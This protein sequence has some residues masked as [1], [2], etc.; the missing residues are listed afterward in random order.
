VRQVGDFMDALRETHTLTVSIFDGR[1][2]L[3]TI[4]EPDETNTKAAAGEPAADD[5]DFQKAPAKQAPK[6]TAAAASDDDV[7]PEPPAKR[8]KVRKQ[9]STVDK[10]AAE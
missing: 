8:S 1:D 7:A 9:Q 6:A 10:E 4:L 3:R 2:E 5:D